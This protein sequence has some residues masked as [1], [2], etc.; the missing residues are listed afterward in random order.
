M[1]FI[2]ITVGILIALVGWIFTYFHKLHFVKKANQLERINKQLK[3][4]YGPLYI[5]LMASNKTWTAFW[6]ANRPAHGENHYFSPNAEVTEE[7]KVIW[8]NWMTNVFEPMNSKTE[9]IILNNIDLLDSDEIPQAFIKAI[10]HIAAY[11]AVL[12]NWKNGSFTSHVSINNW[13]SEELLA[14]VKPE[15]EK[16][17][18][19]QRKLLKT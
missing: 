4:L 2:T 16:L 9:N 7:E 15:Y 18:A 10:S 17:K 1:E 11:K 8:R 3:D 12:A 14:V 6:V 5:R 19:K 13:P